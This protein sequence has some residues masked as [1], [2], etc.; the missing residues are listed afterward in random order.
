MPYKHRDPV[1]EKIMDETEYEGHHSICQFLRDIYHM[2]DNEE[3]KI[4]ARVGVAMAKAMNEKLKWYKAKE[5]GITIKE[6]P[7]LYDLEQ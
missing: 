1:P 2:T 4:K 3:I 5:M 7:E 6:V